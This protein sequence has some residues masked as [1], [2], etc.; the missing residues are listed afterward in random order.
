MNS[1]IKKAF[2]IYIL[3]LFTTL[4]GSPIQATDSSQTANDLEFWEIKERFSQEIVQEEDT[5]EEEILKKTSSI[6]SP[7]PAE[8]KSTEEKQFGV[9]P[10]LIEIPAIDAQAKVIPVGQTADGHMEAPQS[11]YEIAWYEPGIKPGDTGN[12]VL[13]GHVD[14]LSAPGTFYNL[15]K[16]EPGNEIHITGT[17]GTKLVFIVRDKKSYSPEDA[18][19]QEIFGG[20]SESHLNLITCTGDYNNSTGDYEERLVIYTDLIES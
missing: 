15:K 8:E 5:L 17:D 1:F 12:A 6:S 9:T 18:P 3:F 4:S 7:P 13:A 11:I 20:S 2:L 14:G 10:A 16:L 19:I